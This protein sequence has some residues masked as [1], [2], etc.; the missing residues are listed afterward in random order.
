MK[1]VEKT[2]E[3]A[4]IEVCPL[5]GS[6][7]EKGF[8][9]VWRGIFWSDKKRTVVWKLP[10]G[11]D[12]IFRASLKNPMID[13]CMDGLS[14]LRFNIYNYH[15]RWRFSVLWLLVLALFQSCHLFR[16]YDRF[17]QRC[18]MFPAKRERLPNPW[19]CW[20]SGAKSKLVLN[21]LRYQEVC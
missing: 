12:M 1:A 8:I 19:S 13:A 21:S 16:S 9:G 20:T 3:K 4:V 11:E 10:S 2:E 7:M 6:K 18:S 14:T 5:C 15:Y 17:D